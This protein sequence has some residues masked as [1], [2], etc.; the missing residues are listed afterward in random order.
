M[1][2]WT[3]RLPSTT[4]MMP[5]STST[6][7]SEIAASSLSPQPVIISRRALQKASRIAA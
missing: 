5:K 6:E 7:R 4:W 2:A 1:M 3:P